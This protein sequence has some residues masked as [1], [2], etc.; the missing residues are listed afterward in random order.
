MTSFTLARTL[1]AAATGCFIAA[2][3][4]TWTSGVDVTLTWLLAWAACTYMAHLDMKHTRRYRR[5][6]R[7]QRIQRFYRDATNAENRHGVQ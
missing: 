6:L 1:A 5:F 3:V 2:F 7:E 4:S